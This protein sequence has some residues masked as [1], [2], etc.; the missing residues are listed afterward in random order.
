MAGLIQATDGSLYGT[1]FQGGAGN[2]GTIFRLV[3]FPFA[4]FFR[5]IENQPTL[6]SVKAGRA[7]PVKFSLGGDRGLAIMAADSPA[8][9]RITCD[10]GAPIGGVETTS[11]AG[12]SSLTYDAAAGQ[13]VY[14]WNTDSAWANT[15][16]RLIVTLVDGTSHTATF[17]FT[18]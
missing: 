7:I 6:N 16:R 12:R 4:G 18:R 2:F 15:C 14:V 11:S 10:A 9:R 5:P 17:K 13:Y 1:T 8:S 3:T